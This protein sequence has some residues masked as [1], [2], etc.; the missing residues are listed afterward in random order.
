MKTDWKDDVFAGTARKWN[1][2]DNPD[3]TK[4]ITDATEYTQ[5]GDPFGAKELNE[6]GEEVNK[7]QAVKSVTLTTAGW[8]STAPYKQTVNIE[9]ITADDL[10]VIMLDVSRASNWAEEKM[11]RKNFGYISYYDTEAGKITFTAAY[12]KPQV[13]L[14]VG[15]KG[16]S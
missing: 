11:L 7:I 14:T 8:S 10:P 2:A 4:T 6:I 1:I 3:G 12:M 16:V 13:A 9:G 5:E 15:L